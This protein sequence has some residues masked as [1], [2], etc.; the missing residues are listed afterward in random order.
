MIGTELFILSKL[1]FENDVSW[2]WGFFFFLSDSS[3]WYVLTNAIRGE[4]K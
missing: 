2:F 1:F 3:M 4:E